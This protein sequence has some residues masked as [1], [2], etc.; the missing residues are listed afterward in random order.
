MAS[1]SLNSLD[2]GL[3]RDDAF[4]N[5]LYSGSLIAAQGCSS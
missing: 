1:H 4:K 5:T 3:C 2:P